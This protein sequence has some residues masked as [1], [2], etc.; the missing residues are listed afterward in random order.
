MCV[1]T[2]RSEFF[3]PLQLFLLRRSDSDV[4]IDKTLILKCGSVIC[5]IECCVLNLK[6]GQ[7]L[8]FKK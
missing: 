4:K 1:V 6:G 7:K 3:R 5:I 2:L 8:H